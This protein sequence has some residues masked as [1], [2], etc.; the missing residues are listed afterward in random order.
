MKRYV[1][2]Y[3]NGHRV[4][5]SSCHE[6]WNFTN[7]EGTRYWLRGVETPA[8]AFFSAVSNQSAAEFAKKNETHKRVRVLHGSSVGCYVNKWVRR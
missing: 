7:F 6:A 4:E 8:E 5:T 3:P 1:V 2:E